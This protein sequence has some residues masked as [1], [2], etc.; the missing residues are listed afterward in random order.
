MAIKTSRHRNGS[1]L[2]VC[3]LAA[4]ALS[5][6]SI[7]ILRSSRRHIARVDALRSAAVGRCVSE[8]LVQRSIASLRVNPAL[9]GTLIDPKSPLRGARCELRQ[10]TASSA[11]IQVYLYPTS[12]VPAKV[13]IVNHADLGTPVN[14]P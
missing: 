7:A 11:Q 4:F 2:L 5:I 14:Q 8:G 3:T 12:S 13:L 9:T 6:A 10:L 1:A